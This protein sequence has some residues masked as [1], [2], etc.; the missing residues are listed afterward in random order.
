MPRLSQRTFLRAF[1]GLLIVL[2]IFQGSEQRGVAQEKKGE[3]ERKQGNFDP[4]RW[5]EQL[6]TNKNGKLDP[7]ELTGRAREFAAPKLKELGFNPD[8]AISIKS[9]TSAVEKSRAAKNAGPPAVPGFGISP[10]MT[11]VPGFEVELGSALAGIGTLEERYDRRVLA[12]LQQ[13]LDRYDKN[14]D[15]ILDKREI[16]EAR[17]IYGD[18]TKND[19]N[20]D[21]ILTKTELAERYVAREA[22][23]KTERK[24]SDREL[25]KLYRQP[26]E[27]KKRWEKAD[28]NEK[29]RMGEFWKREYDKL[30]DE[31]SRQKTRSLFGLG[32][33]PEA[34]KDNADRPTRTRSSDDEDPASYRKVYRHVSI[35]DKMLA[36]GVPDD[37][38]AK[39]KNGD[40]QVQMNEYET[41][42]TAAKLTQ[43]NE[44][45]LNGD[46][47]I[48]TKEWLEK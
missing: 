27:W 17:W 40:G 30:D 31:E 20:K 3:P 18:P 7:N 23:E 2:S 48:S 25:G 46:G 12:R 11:M 36:E 35:R 37:F 38:I 14:K 47:V 19:L 34:K 28:K 5:L 33:K 1:C 8:R 9:I 6:D 44:L 16:A 43:F 32:G 26:E 15:G 13:T 29:R 4:R 10:E 42:W 41:K 39:D 45:D 21:G 22:Y 24:K